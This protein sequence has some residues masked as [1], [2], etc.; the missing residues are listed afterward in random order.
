MRRVDRIEIAPLAALLAPVGLNVIG[1]V[2]A[3]DYDAGLAPSR[4]LAQLIPG[5]RGVVVIGNGGGAFWAGFAAQRVAGAVEPN[6][7]DTYTRAIVQTRLRGWLPAGA[8]MI[9]PFDYPAMPI[10]FQRMA[11]LAGLGSRSLL[12]VLVHPEFGPWMALRAAIVL[13][14]DLSAPRPAAGFDPCP[15]CV[16][17]ACMAS[18][19]T[20]AVTAAGW[21]IPRCAA[22]RAR[23]DDPCGG[24]CHARFDCVIGRAHRYPDAASAHHQT[25]VRAA[26]LATAPRD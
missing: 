13:P 14:S 26:L 19:P 12:G 24:R 20:G 8:Q 11:E 15:T 16:E 25:A 6:P 7:L 21:D 4:Q 9:F 22:Y 17:R 18:C 1:A 2:S 3:A 5:A 10:S 23:D